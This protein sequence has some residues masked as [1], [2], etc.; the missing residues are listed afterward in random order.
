ME[1]I[2]GGILFEE[3]AAVVPAQAGIQRQL[4]S[5]CTVRNKTRL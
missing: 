1:W 5:K 4:D 2:I 3:L